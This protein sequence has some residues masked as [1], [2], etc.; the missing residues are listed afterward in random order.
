VS[1]CVDCDANFFRG[2]TV[3]VVGS[4]SA[5]IDGALTLLDYAGKVYLAAEALNMLAELLAKLRKTS[6]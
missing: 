1:Y 6:Y 4:S 2:A 5:A 3:L